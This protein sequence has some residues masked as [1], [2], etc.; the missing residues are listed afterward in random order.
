MKN[1]KQEK[2]LAIYKNFQEN[3]KKAKNKYDQEIKAIFKKI[4]QEKLEKLK[5]KIKQT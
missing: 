3:V 1:I 5:A 4:D 2:L